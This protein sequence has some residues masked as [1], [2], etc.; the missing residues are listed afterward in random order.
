MTKLLGRIKNRLIYIKRFTH[1]KFLKLITN[2]T[3]IKTKYGK[4]TVL[5]SDDVIGYLIFLR[6]QY[7]TAKFSRVV[8]FLKEKGHLPKDEVTLLDI[9]ANNG[10]IG[11]QALKMDSV[12]KVIAIEPEPK[13]YDL[14]IENID[15]NNLKDA[16][17]PI[18]VALSDGPKE[19]EFELD[20]KN[21]GD[22]RGRVETDIENKQGEDLRKTIKVPSDSLDNILKNIPSHFSNN[23]NFCW[24]DIQGFEGMALKYG[25]EAFQKGIPSII[26]IWPYGLKRAGMSMEEFHQ[27]LSKYWTHY[28]IIEEKEFEAFSIDSF[29]DLVIGLDKKDG[30]EDILFV[31][32]D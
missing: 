27:I 9:G 10:V 30:F 16:I 31:R 21:S 12:N 2:K 24:M 26:E 13:N 18:Q 20:E 5:L 1:W 7:D 6:R 8:S 15:Q 32:A 23:I 4:Y 14:L 25:A 29:M 19:L 28:Y 22:N 11:I 17:Y 3:I